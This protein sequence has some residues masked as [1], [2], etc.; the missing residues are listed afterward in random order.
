VARDGKFLA[1]S[2]KPRRRRADFTTSPRRGESFHTHAVDWYLSVL[3]CS[4]CRFTKI[5]SGC[6][7][8]RHRR[9]AV[10]SK[11]QTDGSRWIALQRARWELQTL[12]AVIFCGLVRQTAANF[13]ARTSPFL[14]QRRGQTARRNHFSR[15]AGTLPEFGAAQ[16]RCW[17]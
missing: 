9:R 15:R 7:S 6:R 12:P 17:K 13:L 1:A 4:A 14:R 10:K 8:S 3:R 2:M 16:L 11:W 5:L